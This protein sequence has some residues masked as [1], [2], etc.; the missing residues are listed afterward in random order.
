VQPRPDLVRRGRPDVTD[1]VN[2]ALPAGHRRFTSDRLVSAIK[3]LV[4]EALAEPAL[5]RTA[6][7]RRPRKEQAARKRATEVAA[8]LVAGCSDITLEQVGTELTR[9]GLDP[10]RG[11]RQWA[12]SS[13]KALLDRARAAGL[14]APT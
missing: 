9:L 6:Q 14:L 1:A 7:R 11:G 10:A 8:A 4:V 3:L 13:V 5:L 12:P 2:A